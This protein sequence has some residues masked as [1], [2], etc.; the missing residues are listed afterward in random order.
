MTVNSYFQDTTDFI[1]QLNNIEPIP[2]NA[3]LI[4]MDVRSLYTNI[5]NEDGLRALTKLLDNRQ[6]KVPNTNT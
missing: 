5:S 2:A 1:N 6:T 3:L 4:T